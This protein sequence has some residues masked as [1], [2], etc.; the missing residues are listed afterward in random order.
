MRDKGRRA[1][2]FGTRFT[3]AAQGPPEDIFPNGASVWFK[4]GDDGTACGED[5]FWRG[6][7]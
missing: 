7:G 4:S 3:Y 5:V 1:R 2:S 6:D